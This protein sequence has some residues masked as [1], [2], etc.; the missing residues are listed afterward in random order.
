VVNI[1]FLKVDK[2]TGSFARVSEAADA[3]E[4]FRHGHRLLVAVS[5]TV[6]VKELSGCGY[7]IDHTINSSSLP[8]DVSLP[9]TTAETSVSSD[10]SACS[11]LSPDSP[12]YELR[13]V[14]L[15]PYRPP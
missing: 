6:S 8:D 1:L 9:S 10:S 4:L 12:V 13:S 14:K 7:T 11:S 5:N 15:L 3:E 2:L